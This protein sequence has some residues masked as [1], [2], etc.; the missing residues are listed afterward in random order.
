MSSSKKASLLSVKRRSRLFLMGAS[1]I[2]LITSLL[3]AFLSARLQATNADQ[4]IDGYLFESSDVFKHATFPGAHTYLIKWPLFALAG[5]LGSASWAV[6]VLTVLCALI[7][8]AALAVL[9]WR[10]ERRPAVLGIWYLVLSVVLLLV[11]AQPAPG[12]LLPVNFA[13]FTTRNLEYAVF[14][15]IL[16]LLTRT[17]SWRDWSGWVAAGLAALLFASD[18]LFLPLLLGAIGLAVALQFK[19]LRQ[20]VWWLAA[21]FIGYVVAFCATKGLEAW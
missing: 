19:R 18:G 9:L 13:M 15:V 6:T 11:P 10:I 2:L 3:W 7:P 20:A 12:T 16:V 21:A 5:I 17:R 4:L 1:V 8:I 14:L